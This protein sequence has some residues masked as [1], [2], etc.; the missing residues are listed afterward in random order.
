MRLPVWLHCPEGFR[1]EDAARPAPAS[2]EYL[3][4]NTGLNLDFSSFSN[5][6]C[7]FI[8]ALVALFHVASLIWFDWVGCGLIGDEGGLSSGRLSAKVSE[9]EAVLDFENGGARS[10]A[11]LVPPRNSVRA[12]SRRLARKGA[13]ARCGTFFLLALERRFLLPIHFRFQFSRWNLGAHGPVVIEPQ[14]G[15]LPLD[16]AEALPA[17][18]RVGLLLQKGGRQASKFGRE[19]AG[20]PVADFLSIRG[21][22]QV[23]GLL[24]EQAR[25]GKGFLLPQPFGVA[26]L[27]PLGE[28]LLGDGASCRN[29]L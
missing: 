21:F 19:Q 18:F 6:C 3:W 25:Q 5:D 22:I 10:C 1:P 11:L 29:V 28:V 14:L 16:F 15:Q 9:I 26:A 13:R 7:S 8:G 24:G 12:S 20:K 27:L 17:F 23:F 2:V 4:R